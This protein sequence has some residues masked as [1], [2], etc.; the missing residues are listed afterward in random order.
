MLL[1]AADLKEFYTQPLGRV[2]RRLLGARL[3]SRWSDLKSCR[4][5]GLGFVTPYL[6]TFRAEAEPLGAL[7]PAHLGGIVWPEKGQS[8]SVIVEDTEIAI[9]AAG[10]VGNVSRTLLGD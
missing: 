2:V 6:A 3:R 9:V 5:F 7:M 10:A 8:F 4:T 1:D